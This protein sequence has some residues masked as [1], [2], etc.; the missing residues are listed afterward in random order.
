MVKIDMSLGRQFNILESI[1]FYTYLSII[2]YCRPSMNLNW[3]EEAERKRDYP[4]LST[5]FKKV[6]GKP[7]LHFTFLRKFLISHPQRL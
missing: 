2:H 3:R 1:N 7:A 4:Q 5:F 6:F